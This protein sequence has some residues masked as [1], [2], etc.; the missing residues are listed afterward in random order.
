MPNKPDPT[1][2]DDPPLLRSQSNTGHLIARSPGSG[3]T[4]LHVQEVVI[5]NPHRLLVPY[6]DYPGR[7]DGQS[8]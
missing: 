1:A 6:R 5:N 3:Y 7:H 4:I 2:M 8:S